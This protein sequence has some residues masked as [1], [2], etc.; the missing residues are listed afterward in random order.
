MNGMDP[1]DQRN[2]II[3][4][5]LMI[6][7]VFAYQAFI[8]NPEQEA[9]REAQQEQQAANPDGGVTPDAVEGAGQPATVEMAQS[10]EEALQTNQRL[11]FDAARVDGSI[12]LTGAILDDLQLKDHYT[13]VAKENELRLL[14]PTNAAYGY[15]ASWYWFDGN[16]PVAGPATRWQ[17]EGSG[18]LTTTSPVTLTYEGEGL[19]IERTISVDENYLFTFTD[20]IT[21]TG[22]EA[23][24]LQPLG[25]VRRHGDWKEFL[26]ETDPGTSR[27]SGM[28]FQGMIGVFNNDLTW[29]NYKNLNQ[30]KG[31]KKAD[32]QGVRRAETGGWLGFTDK[33]WMTSLIPEQQYEFAGRFER[34][35]RTNGPVFQVTATG[36]GRM[37]QPGETITSE[38]RI[39]SG[40]K[41]FSVLRDYQD[42]GIPRF[43]DAIDWG[44]ILYYVTKPLFQLLF[45]LEHNLGTFGLAILALTVLVRLPLVPLYNQSYK[46]RAKMKKLAEPMKEL[47]ERFAAD[48]Q[49]RQQEIMKL[50]QREK[51]NPIA[52]CIPI[53]LTIPVFFALYKTLYVT[54]EMRHSAF[55]W[56]P[57]LSAPDTLIIGNLFGLFPWA[58]AQEIHNMGVLSFIL[59]LGVLAMLYGATMAAI[60]ALSP[61][62]TDPT[63]KA[64]MR[65]LPLIF[66]FVFAGFAS[67]LVMYWVWSNTLSLIQQYFIMRRNGVETELDKLIARLMGREKEEA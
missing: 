39:F 7:F 28:A 46:S 14:R 47:Q 8:V 2:F 5:V 37:I 19:S 57:D 58:S 66:M 26:D 34:L 42:A 65:F 18:Q 62:P 49:R 36:A 33:Y 4:M 29:R 67:G 16:T 55:L 52:G 56:L 50:Y 9:R 22:G 6:A 21:N 1:Q 27:T 12:R 59:G 45:W 41:E 17:A 3:A 64:V 54:I 25:S 15:Y 23:R 10:V 51:A 11:T 24:T 63:Q 13:T 53:L 48:P 43:E 32:D 30:N 40:A 31:L 61:P 44:N 20:R 60:Q 38:N 35:S